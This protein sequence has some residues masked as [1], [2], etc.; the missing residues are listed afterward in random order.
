[1]G[2]GDPFPLWAYEGR[3]R[4]KPEE[5][6]G[7]PTNNLTLAHNKSTMCRTCLLMPNT[8]LGVVVVVVVGKGKKSSSR[9]MS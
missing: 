1:M 8:T 3:R 2:E 4:S 9:F 5:T 7:G 6:L